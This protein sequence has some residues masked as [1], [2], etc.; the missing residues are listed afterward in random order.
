MENLGCKICPKI[1]SKKDWLGFLMNFQLSVVGMYSSIQMYLFAFHAA[2]QERMTVTN[3]VDELRYLKSFSSIGD[4]NL[5]EV[6]L[7]LQRDN[8]FKVD[9]DLLKIL[10]RMKK[11][12]AEILAYVI[13]YYKTVEPQFFDFLESRL[14]DL[15]LD[16]K[17]LDFYLQIKP[18]QT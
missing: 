7:I 8:H 3:K 2:I 1:S 4:S 6:V 13:N 12:D 11:E 14:T 18:I 9:Q 16:S 15:F 5:R 17:S 10:K